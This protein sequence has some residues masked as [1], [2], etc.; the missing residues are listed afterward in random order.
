MSMRR[1]LRFTD[2]NDILDEVNRIGSSDVQTVGNWSYYQ[3]LSHIAG[4]IE[5]SMTSYPRKLP[6]LVRKTVGPLVFRQMMKSGLMKPG[7]LNPDAPKTREEGDAI[8]AAQRLRNAVTRFKSYE[9]PVA[10]HPFFGT[11]NKDDYFKLHSIH[12]AHH[13]G[14]AHPDESVLQ[15]AAG[16]ITSPAK[17]KTGTAKRGKKAPASSKKSPVKSKKTAG[18]KAKKAFR[19]GAR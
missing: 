8:A 2:L 4:G 3:I 15:V 18:K 14:Y 6:A 12:A 1:E 19:K 11:L 5:H 16:F 17:G 7:N 10:E 9:G 13:L